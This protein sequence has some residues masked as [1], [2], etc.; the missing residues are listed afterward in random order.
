MVVIQ[1]SMGTS[2]TTRLTLSTTNV[3]ESVST[4]RMEFDARAYQW[5]LPHN[6]NVGPH[7]VFQSYELATSRLNTLRNTAWR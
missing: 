2:E 7:N 6:Q 4:E 1:D 3:S 5:I